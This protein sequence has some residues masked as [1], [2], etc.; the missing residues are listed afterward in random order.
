ML[1]QIPQSE[2]IDSGPAVER[3]G[4]AH[5]VRRGQG[6][7]P[8]PAVVML[9]GRSGDE[10]VM[11]VFARAL[12]PGWLVVA[13]RAPRPDPDSGYSWLPRRPG[14]W[15][16]LELFDDAV[17]Y[18][19][20]LALALP[21]LYQADGRAIHLMGFSQGAA[22]AYAAAL[23]HPRLVRGVAGLVGFMPPAP[24]AV[25]AVAPLRGLPVFAATGLRDEI[26]PLEVSRA[27]ADRLRAAGAQL[28]YREY[29]TGHKLDAAGMRD[30]AAWWRARS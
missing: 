12:P 19:W 24:E 25:L 10:T 5:R 1:S 17:A 18:V 15:P 23:R 21:E 16:A 14:E 20:R 7:G 3:A 13:P 22:L 11:W 4:L 26:I 6:A 9:H 30:L 2:L 8:H 29:D 28:D 27:G